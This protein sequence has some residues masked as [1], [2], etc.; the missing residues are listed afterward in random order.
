[1]MGFWS[2]VK[3][4]FDRMGDDVKKYSD[5]APERRKKRLQKLKDDTEIAEAEAKLNKAKKKA[6]ESKLPI[7]DFF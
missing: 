7:E 6:Q 5:D 2:S 3:K 1:M 4:G